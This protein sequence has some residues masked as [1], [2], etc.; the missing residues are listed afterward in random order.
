[1]LHDEA[2]ADLL[3][4]DRHA[5]TGLSQTFSEGAITPSASSFSCFINFLQ[6]EEARKPIVLVVDSPAAGKAKAFPQPRH[7][8][9]TRDGSP[10]RVEGLEATDLWHVLLYPEMV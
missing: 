4:I 5:T 1:M 7:R 3:N 10:R 9:E 6:P 2:R 8:L